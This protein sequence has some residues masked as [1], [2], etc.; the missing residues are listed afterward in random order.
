MQTLLR[1]DEIAQRLKI[2]GLTPK[3]LSVRAGINF[4][5]FYRGRQRPGSTSGR[6]L[7]ALGRALVARE[8]ELRDHLLR[9]HPLEAIHREAAE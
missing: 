7:D 1:I 5:T 3:E 4:A 8:I 9:L 2:I 6:N